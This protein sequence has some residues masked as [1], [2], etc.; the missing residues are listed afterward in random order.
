MTT[1]PEPPENPPH[2]HAATLYRDWL[3]HAASC[4]GTC[5]MQGVDCEEARHLREEYRAASDAMRAFPEA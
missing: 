5:R 3:V 2:T 4:K 1:P